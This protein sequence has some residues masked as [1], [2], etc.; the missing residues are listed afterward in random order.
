MDRINVLEPKSP[1]ILAA[2]AKQSRKRRF[3][4]LAV[5]AAEARKMPILEQI[6]ENDAVRDEGIDLFR[7]L[8]ADM[9]AVESAEA[10]F[11]D[12]V[13]GS[14]QSGSSSDQPGT[15]TTDGREMDDYLAVRE[16]NAKWRA[17]L[18]ELLSNY[19]QSNDKLK[20]TRSKLYASNRALRRH[21][22]KVAIPQA[23]KPYSS[24]SERGKLSAQ[25]RLLAIVSKAFPHNSDEDNCAML[26]SAFP[27]AFKRIQPLDPAQ[28]LQ[29]QVCSSETKM[30]C[31][32]ERNYKDAA[33][34]LFNSD[35]STSYQFHDG[36]SSA[37]YATTG[38][39]SL[40]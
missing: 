8:L 1:L 35:R 14:L 3:E 30:R 6:H 25:K 26:R 34:A 20:E 16:Q 4:E 28:T 13:R 19:A 9:E 36:Q 5:H 31:F 12:E 18:E 15:S 40:R 29:F 22:G 7:T 17:Q 38:A 10:E 21:Q 37:V 32:R 2:E 23:Q 33:N 24:M 11:D 27:E 39:D